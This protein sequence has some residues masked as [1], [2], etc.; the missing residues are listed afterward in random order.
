MKKFIFSLLA[1]TYSIISFAQESTEVDIE[2]VGLDQQIDQAFEPIS[3]FATQVVFFEVYNTPFVLILLVASAL[4][5][6]LYFGFPNIR[7]FWRAIQTVRGKYEDIEKHGAKILYGEDGVAQ[8][9]DLNKV[10]DIEDHL[11]NLESDLAVDG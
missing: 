3:N 2:E 6:T 8:G 4:F 9:T 1:F 7:Y 10:D 5:F 11:V